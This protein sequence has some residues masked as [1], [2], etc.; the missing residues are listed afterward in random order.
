MPNYDFSY[1]DVSWLV[2]VQPQPDYDRLALAHQL[3]TPLLPM[4]VFRILNYYYADPDP[5]FSP[6]GSGSG[7]TQETQETQIKFKKLYHKSLINTYC[8]YF[9]QF[10]FFKII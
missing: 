2:R 1:L 9:L 3:L 4:A 5:N 7:G 6:F 10:Y 8:R